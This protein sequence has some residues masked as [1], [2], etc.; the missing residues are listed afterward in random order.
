LRGARFNTLRRRMAKLLRS[1]LPALLSAG[2]PVTLKEFAAKKF[3]KEVRRVRDLGELQHSASPEKLHRVRC[4]LRR[5]RYLGEFFGPALGGSVS[6]LTRRL[7]QAEKPL[8]KIHDLDV[9]LSL[10]QRSGPAA[11]RAFSELLHS[12]RAEHLRNVEPAWNR[13]VVFEKKTRHELKTKPKRIRLRRQ[14]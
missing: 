2:S 14:V 12:Q 6:K 4:A 1:Q 8:A 11:P 5:A 9:G 7:H 10:I 13:L 3:L